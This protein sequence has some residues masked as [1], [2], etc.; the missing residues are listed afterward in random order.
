M[1]FQ[2]NCPYISILEK[3][4]EKREKRERGRETQSERDT[5]T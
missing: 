2:I 3:M 1:Q 5:E 4:R